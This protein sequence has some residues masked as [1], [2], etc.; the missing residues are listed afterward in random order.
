MSE[1]WKTPAE[2]AADNLP[3][4]PSTAQGITLRAKKAAWHS[5]PR[6]ASGGG[7]EYPLSA[8]PTAARAAYVARHLRALD[9]PL[10][11]AKAAASEPEAE[12]ASATALD[13]RDGRLAIL[14]AVDDF[15]AAAG[16]GRKRADALFCAAYAAGA[17]EVTPWVREA[18]KSVT[19]RTLARWRAVKAAGTTHRLA[20]D[21]GAARRGKGVLEIANTGDVK[22]F[23]LALLSRNPLFTAD[24]V[25]D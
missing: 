18:V 13:Q 16:I 22:V 3:G 7:R 5:R 19:P 2:W 4:L 21:K 24:H 14:A 9:V 25:R 17:V 10:E 12:L 8:L 23:C 11:V 15:A 1:I 6:Q 20:V